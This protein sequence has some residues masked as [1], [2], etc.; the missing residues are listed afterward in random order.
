MKLLCSWILL[1]GCA[2]AV[3]MAREA[4]MPP[5]SRPAEGPSAEV[6]GRVRLWVAG[7]SDADP[8]M[9]SRCRYEL[10]GLKRQELPLLRGVLEEL[11]PLDPLLLPDLRQI[12]VHVY[13]SGEP[14]DAERSGFLGIRMPGEMDDEDAAGTIVVKDRMPGFCGYRVLRD[15]DVI[16]DIEER[17]LAQPA[18]RQQFIDAVQMLNAGQQ[19]HLKVLR[20]GQPLRLAVML[21]AR[22]VDRTGGNA[23]EYEGRVRELAESR[24]RAAQAYIEKNFPVLLDGNAPSPDN[25]ASLRR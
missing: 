18:E 8:A 1:A 5:A 2:A 20:Q 22:P 7:L 21:D 11:A 6:V 14:Y 15:G 9:R 10:M 13:L 4:T 17:A 19:V 23:L 12:V 24:A 3:P 25:A 16:V